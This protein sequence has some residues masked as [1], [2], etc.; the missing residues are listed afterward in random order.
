MHPVDFTNAGPSQALGFDPSF[1]RSPAVA[2]HNLQAPADGSMITPNQNPPV[3]S[4][5]FQ[6]QL[7]CAPMVMLG[8]SD[9]TVVFDPEKGRFS[10]QN[11]H[12]PT[13]L[14]QGPVQAPPLPEDATDDPEQSVVE[15]SALGCVAPGLQTEVGTLLNAHAWRPRLLDVLQSPGKIGAIVD[16]QSGVAIAGISAGARALSLPVGTDPI[17]AD[18]STRTCV[19][20]LASKPR[21]PAS[22]LSRASK[23]PVTPP[24]KN[25]IKS[26][27]DQNRIWAR[28]GQAAAPAHCPVTPG[29]TWFSPH[30]FAALLGV[31]SDCP[32]HWPPHRLEDHGQDQ[33]RQRRR[34]GHGRRPSG[35]R[36]TPEGPDHG[37]T[38]L[39][40]PEEAPDC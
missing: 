27:P 5:D 12:T 28:R 32:S 8:S 38:P 14:S 3:T 15:I 17:A 34:G 19:I 4:V 31:P 40:Q 35:A 21:A 20:S 26:R 6:S 13:T 2:T 7:A 30:S 36:D 22:L 16:S 23:V 11:L 37:A 9:P 24:E 39:P 33:G 18:G 29:R 1:V 25:K 10:L